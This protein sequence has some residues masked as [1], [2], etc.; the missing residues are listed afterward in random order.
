MKSDSVPGRPGTTSAT[1]REAR[2]ASLPTRRRWPCAHRRPRTSPGWTSDQPRLGASSRV[3]D[4]V[5]T[6]PGSARPAPTRRA[7]AGIRSRTSAASTARRARVGSGCEPTKSPTS[8]RSATTR[9]RRSTTRAARNPALTW[10]PS[11]ASLS[12]ATSG[13]AGRPGPV[14]PAGSSSSSTPSATR[15]STSRDAV[16]RVIEVRSATPARE[17]GSGEAQTVRATRARLLARKE[18][19]RAPDGASTARRGSFGST[20]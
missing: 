16:E 14:V 1:V 18:D 10:R 8:S 12:P 4:P 3:P 15:S 13:V 6:M 9:P 20:A 17:I 5:D 19:C 11:A 7:V 2:S